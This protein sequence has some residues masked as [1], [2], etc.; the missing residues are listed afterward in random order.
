MKPYDFTDMFETEGVEP[1]EQLEKTR[2]KLKDIGASARKCLASSDF[3]AYKKVFEDELA[4]IMNAMVIYTANYGK[5]GDTLETYALNMIRF[6]QRITDLRKLLTY[7]ELD[8][9]K[10]IDQPKEEAHG[11]S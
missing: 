9:K 7:V 6:V 10:G 3:Q 5:Q 2:L 8:A 4:G 1:A 11:K